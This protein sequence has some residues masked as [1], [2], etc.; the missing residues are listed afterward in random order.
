MLFLL[1]AEAV[2]EVIV[3]AAVFVLGDR[4]GGVLHYRLPYHFGQEIHLPFRVGNVLVDVDL[5]KLP[6]GI[7]L[8]KLGIVVHLRLI[9]G[10]L[11]IAVGGY[12]GVWARVW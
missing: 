1:G 10:E 2:G 12:R 6:F 8:Y 5:H 3:T 9:V 11:F 7:A 4:C